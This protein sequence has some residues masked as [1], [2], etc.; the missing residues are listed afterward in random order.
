MSESTTRHLRR[1]ADRARSELERGLR[2]SQPCRSEELLIRYPELAAQPALALELIT[3]EFALRH[4]LGQHPS[5]EVFCSRFPQWRD[6]LELRLSALPPTPTCDS[7][8][9]PTVLEPYRPT[10]MD[11]SLRKVG[12]Y[13]LLERIGRGGMGDV[14]RARQVPPLER[15]VALKLLR[16]GDEFELR[17]FLKEI[18]VARRLR[19]PNVLPIYDADALDGEYYYTMPLLPAG[20]LETRLRRGRPEPRWTAALM[21]KVAR[22]LHY[23]HQQGVLH[24]D[25]KPANILLDEHDEPLVADFGLAKLLDANL[26]QTQP[27]QLLGS[28]PYMSPEQA[29]G[30]SH[31][32]TAASDVWSLGVILYEMLTG[33]RPFQGADHSEV[34]RRIQRLEPFRPRQLELDV[35]RELETICLRC[36]EKDPAWRYRSAEELADDLR[37]WL[38]GVPLPPEPMAARLRRLLPPLGRSAGF[39]LLFLILGFLPIAL[40]PSAMPPGK[41]A[42][43]GGGRQTLLTE[44]AK[45]RPGKP[46]IV[47][48]PNRTLRWSRV[49]VGNPGEVVPNL[50]SCL[51]IS[52][53]SVCMLE[54]LPPNPRRG[55][56]RFTVRMR[57]TD[58]IRA[59]GVGLYV[60][61]EMHRTGKRGHSFVRL[62]FAEPPLRALAGENLQQAPPEQIN[63]AQLGTGFVRELGGDRAPLFSRGIPQFVPLT[64]G[65]GSKGRSPY[66][67]FSLEMTPEFVRAWVDG[68][69]PRQTRRPQDLR[70]SFRP[71]QHLQRDLRD[72][73]PSFPIGGGIG[74]FVVGGAA[75]IQ[76]IEWEPLPEAP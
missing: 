45:A 25:L 27:G 23:A 31:C 59:G 17:T 73:A 14:Y 56:F 53:L 10:V 22:A 67:T 13:E 57:H 34:L 76:S 2:G 74:V 28:T 61:R 19:H 54:V 42:T 64:A 55:S 35:P 43:Q 63:N 29:A 44:E 7:A 50:G 39:V 70:D 26:T 3:L 1:L 66:R 58:A 69:Q 33:Q 30:R 8:D 41:P 18:E 46:L 60:G 49:E 47:L 65:V 38:D 21:E 37:C 11:A 32:V 51:G 6:A 5:V 12:R 24:R 68:Q 52:T 20:S 36:L 9:Q 72:L 4:E 40:G 48:E 62:E 16:T 71:L 75:E 15:I